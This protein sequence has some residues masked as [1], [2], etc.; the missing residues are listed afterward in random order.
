MNSGDSVK[1]DLLLGTNRS[2]TSVVRRWSVGNAS[3]R[4]VSNA[5]A[6]TE[7]AGEFRDLVRSRGTLYARRL[8]RK[9]LRYRGVNV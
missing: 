4:Q 7:F 8:A 9:A 6:G 1:W 5:L 3:T 2:V